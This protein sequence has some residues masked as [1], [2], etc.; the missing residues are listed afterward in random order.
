MFRHHLFLLCIFVENCTPLFWLFMWFWFF[1]MTNGKNRI[2]ERPQFHYLKKKYENK[3]IWRVWQKP[4][5]TNKVLVVGK[6]GFTLTQHLFMND[7]SRLHSRILYLVV[8]GMFLGMNGYCD[9]VLKGSAFTTLLWPWGGVVQEFFNLQ[10]EIVELPEVGS[11]LEG[12]LVQGHW[13]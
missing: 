8:Y 6:F 11:L 13:N 4:T 5:D 9:T 1:R 10:G 12:I 3:L 7:E 2:K